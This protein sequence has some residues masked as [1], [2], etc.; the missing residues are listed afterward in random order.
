M[1]KHNTDW[2]Y[3]FNAEIMGHGAP[4]ESNTEWRYIFNAEI[5]GHGAP[6]ESNTEWRDVFNAD[7]TGH[8]AP[9]EECLMVGVSVESA[10]PQLPIDFCLLMVP[11]GTPR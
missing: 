2:R 9:W 5:M 1:G 4:W 8:S 10:L 3:V 6:W 11:F 7:I